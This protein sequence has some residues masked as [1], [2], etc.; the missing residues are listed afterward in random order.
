MSNTPFRAEAYLDDHGVLR[1]VESD[2]CVPMDCL[3][4]NAPVGYDK[5]KHQIAYNKEIDEFLNFI[6]AN[7]RKRSAEE[8]SEIRANVGPDAIDVF[9]GERIFP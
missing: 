5:A 4:A 2:H 6:R 1:W 7:P 9:T 8:L 3:D